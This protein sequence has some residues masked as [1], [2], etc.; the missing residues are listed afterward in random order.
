MGFADRMEGTGE[1]AS[2]ASHFGM[3]AGVKNRMVLMDGLHDL[4]QDV[5]PFECPELKAVQTIFHRRLSGVFGAAVTQVD[6]MAHSAAGAGKALFAV[7][8]TSTTDVG[9]VG[10]DSD[11]LTVSMTPVASLRRLGMPGGFTSR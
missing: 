11:D 10:V 2:C 5:K 7:M 9:A 4:V 3:V 8:P 1:A 6:A